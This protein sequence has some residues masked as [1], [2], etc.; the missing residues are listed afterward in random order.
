MEKENNKTIAVRRG[1]FNL[2]KKISQQDF[3]KLKNR[4]ANLT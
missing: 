2:R 1:K 3:F 4:N